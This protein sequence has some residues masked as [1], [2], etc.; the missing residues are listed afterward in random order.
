MK[1]TLRRN[2]ETACRLGNTE[3]CL[4]KNSAKQTQNSANTQPKTRLKT[5]NKQELRKLGT[6]TQLWTRQEKQ[7]GKGTKRTRLE[8]RADI[9]QDQTQQTK[10]AAHTNTAAKTPVQT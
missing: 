8:R 4:N 7:L 10:N 2:T 9:K 1:A 6:A 3:L 5:Q